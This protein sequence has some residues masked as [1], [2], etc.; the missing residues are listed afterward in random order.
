MSSL[1]IPI[2]SK[3][4]DRLCEKHKDDIHSSLCFF[5]AL[6]GTGESEPEY[7]TEF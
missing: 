4:Q 5:C 1:V 6:V 3:E 2:L 7:S